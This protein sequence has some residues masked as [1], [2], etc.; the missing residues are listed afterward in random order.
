MCGIIDSVQLAAQD[1][2]AAL[3]K[4]VRL[5]VIVQMSHCETALMS[6]ILINAFWI[7]FTF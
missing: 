1:S 5:G 6:L 3:G 2:A 4:A 7:Y